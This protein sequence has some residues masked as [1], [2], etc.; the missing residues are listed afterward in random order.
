LS[1]LVIRRS[2]SAGFVFAR[3]FCG[4]QAGKA[5]AILD[6]RDTRHKTDCGKPILNWL[7]VT[8]MLKLRVA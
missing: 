8:V 5:S 2:R 1:F 6:D 4:A 3:R 7:I